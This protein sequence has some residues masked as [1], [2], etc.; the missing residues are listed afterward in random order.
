MSYVDPRASLEQAV[1]DDPRNAI[2]H[3]RLGAELAEAREYDAAVSEMSQAL[4][5]DA[6]LHMARFQLGLLHL[7]MA[8]P[9]QS[10]ETW[11]LLEAQPDASLRLFKRGLEALIRDDFAECVQSLEAGI[12]VNQANAPLNRDMQ[13]VIDKVRGVQAQNA[14]AAT[15]AQ[16]EPE[17]PAVRTDFSLYEP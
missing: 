14:A 8:H 6:N 12:R 16:T 10:I 7:T 5:L 9:Q 2:L 13:M 1:K 15:K 11:A 17:T 4:A 3:Y